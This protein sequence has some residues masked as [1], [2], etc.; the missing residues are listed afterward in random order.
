M[1]IC[2]N[3]WRGSARRSAITIFFFFFFVDVSAT[4]MCAACHELLQRGHSVPLISSVQA[5]AHPC[6]RRLAMAVISPPPSKPQ[7][8]T[9]R[10]PFLL[11]CSNCSAFAA[12]LSLLLLSL[13]YFFAPLPFF[14]FIHFFCSSLLFFKFHF[15]K[16]SCAEL[17]WI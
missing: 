12:T 6:Q 1:C 4:R 9:I 7:C 10:G 11:C 16:K 3:E 17:N 14:S 15:T 2:A 8:H 5:P 13:Y